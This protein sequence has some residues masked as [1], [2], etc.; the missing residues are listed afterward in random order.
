M[1]YS[2]LCLLGWKPLRSVLNF[3]TSP[4][5]LRNQLC[6]CAEVAQLARKS[7]M[8][9]VV[10]VWLQTRETVQYQGTSD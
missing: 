6:A 2:R 7:H 5:K 10:T 4:T 1:F 8:E 9:M 3:M